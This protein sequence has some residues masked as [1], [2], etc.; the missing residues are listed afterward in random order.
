LIKVEQELEEKV[1]RTSAAEAR[2]DREV[3]K[4]AELENQMLQLREDALKAT[5]DCRISVEARANAL[6]AA[7][8]ATTLARQSMQIRA[9]LESQLNDAREELDS[10]QV[11]ISSL[12]KT[13]EKEKSRTQAEVNSMAKQLLLHEK[14]LQARRTLEEVSR[15][16]DNKLSTRLVKKVAKSRG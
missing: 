10:K 8:K 2:A 3:A 16:V 14:Q 15:S 11:T 6:S 1:K 7:N 9:R 5:T 13:L 4:R 12:I